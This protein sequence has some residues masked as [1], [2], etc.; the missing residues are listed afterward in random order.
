VNVGK[1]NRIAMSDFTAVLATTGA[2]DVRTLLNS[3]NAVCT[4]RRSAASLESAVAQALMKQLGLDVPVVTRTSE[5][6]DAVVALDPLADVADEPSRYLVVFLD[7]EPG[8]EA[9]DALRAVD[10]GEE[11]WHVH[12]RELYLWLPSGVADSAVNKQLMRG[13]LGVTW[14]ARN[15]S[16][17]LKLQAAL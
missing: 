10:A 17:V 13:A 15:W 5:E 3:G 16:T 4:S 7:R 1:G 6:I 9:I 11:V 14:T 2:T 8:A 12:G